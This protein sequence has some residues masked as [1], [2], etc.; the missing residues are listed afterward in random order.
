MISKEEF[1]SVIEDVKNAT[2]YQYGLNKYFRKSGVDGYIFQ[3]DCTATVL[4]L[5]SIVFKNNY[6]LIED[7]VYELDFGKKWEPGCI[8]D[9][10]G[11]DIKLETS[12]DLYDYLLSCNK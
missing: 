6:Q 10:Y 2:K 9:E 4:R 12:D 8:K 11:A 3:P 5:L 7:F 1:I